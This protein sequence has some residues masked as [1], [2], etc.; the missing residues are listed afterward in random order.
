MKG[1]GGEKRGMYIKCCLCTE[2]RSVNCLWNFVQTNHFSK[3]CSE[4][5]PF[6]RWKR[7]LGGN[8]KHT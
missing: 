4:E 3:Y 8:I 6:V 7:K 1:V 2:T 5:I